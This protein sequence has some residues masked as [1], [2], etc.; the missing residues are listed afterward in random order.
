MQRNLETFSELKD[1]YL[2][3]CPLRKKEEN[4]MNEANCEISE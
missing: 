3:R 1:E 4:K 2:H